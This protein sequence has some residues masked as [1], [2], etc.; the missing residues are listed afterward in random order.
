MD[1]DMPRSGAIWAIAIGISWGR[2][3]PG[4]VVS[5]A[6][7]DDAG[8]LYRHVRGVSSDRKNHRYSN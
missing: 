3:P 8:F 5:P 2:F 6:G 1:W 7:M 4:R